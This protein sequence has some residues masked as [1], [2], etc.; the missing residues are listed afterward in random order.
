VI[1]SLQLPARAAAISQHTEVRYRQAIWAK[2]LGP[3]HPLLRSD[4]ASA[5]RIAFTDL[6]AFRAKHYVASGATLILVGDFD[7]RAVAKTIG[8]LW[9]PWPNRPRVPPSLVPPPAPVPGPSYVALNKPDSQLALSVT[10]TARSSPVADAAT[11]RIVTELIQLRI[12]SLRE[13]L[14]TTYGLSASYTDL[15]GGSLLEI[16]GRVDLQRAADSIR[17]LLAELTLDHTDPAELARQIERARRLALE[18]CLARGSSTAGAASAILRSVSQGLS[19]DH[20]Q[21]LANAVAIA[22]PSD[23]VAQFRA[24]LDARRMVVGATGPSA[25]ATLRA[26]GAQFVATFQ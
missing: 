26:A 18:S 11:R 23:V 2:L 12:S 20:E 3:D 7:P 8:A 22:R 13:R 24:D 17:A 14:A 10:F 15:P 21:Q 9:G 5:L 25:A 16:T 4:R 19:F 6:E 1:S